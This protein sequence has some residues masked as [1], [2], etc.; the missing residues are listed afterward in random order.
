MCKKCHSRLTWEEMENAK[1]EAW[2]NANMEIA[3]H[4]QNEQIM[5]KLT[6]IL[7]AIKEHHV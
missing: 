3:L 7:Y 6:D 2:G 1:L 4:W 5:K